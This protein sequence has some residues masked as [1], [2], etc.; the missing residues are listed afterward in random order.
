MEKLEKKLLPDYN[1]HYL[2]YSNGIIESLINNKLNKRE[3]SYFLKQRFDKYGYLTVCLSDKCYYKPV[4]VHRIVAKTFIENPNNYPIVNHI[5]GI[6]TDNRVENLE[7]CT[8]LQNIEHAKKNGLIKSGGD[9]Y[10][11]QKIVDTI[12]KKTYNT[13]KEL[14]IELNFLDGMD[15]KYDRLRYLIKTN[16]TKYKYEKS[17]AF[18]SSCNM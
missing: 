1:G 5:N 15:I 10:R 16:K 13:I 7:W 2:V 6:K 4:K 8:N 17:R 3:N 9:C 12:S 14:W 11:A 18:N